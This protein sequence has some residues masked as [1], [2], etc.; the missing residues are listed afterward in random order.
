MLYVLFARLFRLSRG[1]GE[2]LTASERQKTT[3]HKMATMKSMG[4][5][6]KEYVKGGKSTMEKKVPIDATTIV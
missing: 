2:A 6:R 4:N 3:S 1:W 5:A